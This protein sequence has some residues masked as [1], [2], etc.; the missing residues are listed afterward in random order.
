MH[1]NAMD[2]D[3]VD[4]GSNYIVHHSTKSSNYNI[5]WIKALY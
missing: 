3:T 2:V 1:S 5:I 4:T